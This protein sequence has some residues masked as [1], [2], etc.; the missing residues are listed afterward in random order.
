MLTLD[1]VYPS[2]RLVSVNIREIGTLVGES[3]GGKMIDGKVGSGRSQRR[4]GEFGHPAYIDY[5]ESWRSGWDQR[6]FPRS[7][8]A[9]FLCIELPFRPQESGMTLR[10]HIFPLL[11]TVK[12]PNWIR[13]MCLVQPCDYLKFCISRT[14]DSHQWDYKG[15]NKFLWNLCT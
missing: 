8:C 7:S 1:C 4:W 11:C 10:S 12:M 14:D 5:C 13:K 6:L 15:G 3:K 2:H 9:V